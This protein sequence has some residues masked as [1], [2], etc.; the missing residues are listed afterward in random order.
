M[1]LTSANRFELLQMAESVAQEKNIDQE[2]VLEA[3]E[4]SM[5]K[6]ARMRYG[7]E[8]DIRAKYNKET[9]DLTLQRVR[10]VVEEVENM[11]TELTLEDAQ[12][13]DPDLQLGSE[14]VEELPPVGVDELDRINIQVAKQVI[15][16]KVREAEMEKQFE[17]YQDKKGQIIVGTVKGV[18]QG[19]IIVELTIGETM[20]HR[21]QKISHESPEKGTR[22]RAYVMDVTRETRAPQVKLSRTANEFMRELFRSEVPEFYEGTIDIKC[23]ARDP[24][25]RAKIA[26][27]S[28]DASIDPVGAC[29]GMRG[30]RV[31]TVVNELQGER[32]DVIP[33]TENA[34]EF[35]TYALQP[36]KVSKG[37]LDEQGNPT[38]IVVPDDQLS[39]AIGRRGQ[40]VRLA[41]SLTGLDIE[42]VT[43]TYE[44]EQRQ[45]IINQRQQLFMDAIDVDET[46]AHLL[47]TEGFD[48][49]DY[50]AE[51]TIE[52]ILTL[53]GVDEE[54]AVELQ[55]RA[56]KYVEK[57]NKE[58]LAEARRYGLKDDLANFEGLNPK[59]LLE[60]AKNEITTLEEFATLADWELSGGYTEIKGKQIWE[61]GLLEDYNINAE[62]AQYLIISARVSIGLMKPEDIQAIYKEQDDTETESD[63]GEVEET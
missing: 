35:V 16:R 47:V 52:E 53:N 34:F 41:R 36:A 11:S 58:F 18:E 21:T 27:V 55:N 57:E 44:R 54:I 9:G 17:E 31:Q 2:I 46:F 30:S 3:M 38:T 7:S 5:A 63:Q 59:M 37:I 24:G 43:E 26:V 12:K 25:S 6:A 13:I 8:L 15:H 23:I 39:L 42:I 10:T 4:E 1:S 50:L 22:I 51:C 33:W 32:V 29:V 19:N 45:E 49:I 14:I 48:S 40:N 61:R 62:D 60:L 56:R 28:F 20:I